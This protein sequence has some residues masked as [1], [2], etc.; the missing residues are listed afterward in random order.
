M[1]QDDFVPVAI[2]QAFQRRQ[3]DAEGDFWRKIASQ[4]P[5]GTPNGT[6]QGLYTAGAD[7][8]FYGYV[9]HRNPIRDRKAIRASLAKYQ[10]TQ[11]FPISP[12]TPDRNYHPSLQSG[13]LKIRVR[14]K[15]LGGYPDTDDAEKQIFQSALSRD[16]LWIRPD[17]HRAI[18][19]GSFPRTLQLRIAQYHLDDNT[20]GEPMM[21]RIGDLRDV[22][23]RLQ[24]GWITGH[25]RMESADG[26]RGYE[27]VLRGEVQ[28]AKEKVIR[29]DMVALGEYWGE[30]RY[31]KNPPPGRFP[32]GISFSLADGTDVADSIAPQ[33]YKVAHD[34]YLNN[35]IPSLGS[36]SP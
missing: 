28:V 23:F 8:R 15:V 12:G 33:G 3:K 20:R 26:K 11:T 19:K 35:Q 10:S 22:E 24:Q 21:W 4:G 2:D 16:N 36:S 30:G 27:A 9:N 32:L 25:V 29:F 13:G 14:A 1:L 6:T 31:T 7:G 5:R 18:T 34:G 17:E